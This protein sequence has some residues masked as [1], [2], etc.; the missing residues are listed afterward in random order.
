M[1]ISACV[2]F[3]FGANFE[4]NF[5][6]DY[7]RYDVSMTIVAVVVVVGRFKLHLVTVWDASAA[8]IHVVYAGI[9]PAS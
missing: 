1:F 7:V 4:F 9:L 6:Y 5:M 2:C 3:I 8:D